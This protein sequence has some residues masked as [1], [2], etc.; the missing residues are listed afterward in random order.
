MHKHCCTFVVVFIDLLKLDV[1][2]TWK[3]IRIKILLLAGLTIL[4]HAT[5][6]HHHHFDS[7]EAHTENL[8]CKTTNSDSHNENPDTHCHAFNL[9]FSE[10]GSDL[11]ILSAPASNYILDLFSI[12]AAFDFA[13]KLNEANRTPC[14]IFFPYKQIFLTNHSL[15][16]PPATV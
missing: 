8:E 15:R 14:F 13:S 5:I 2:S 7:I 11:T 1:N 16:A 3:N 12:N 10:N 4:L 9:I 6:P